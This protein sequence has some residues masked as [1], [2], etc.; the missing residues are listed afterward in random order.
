M[1]EYICELLFLDSLLIYDNTDFFS[2]DIEEISFPLAPQNVEEEHNLELQADLI[3]NIRKNLNKSNSDWKYKPV[4]GIDLIQ[5]R[6]RI[7]VPQTLCKSVLKW[8]HCYL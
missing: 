7:Y 3:T 8:Y 6:K 1:E 4:E 5:Y 2:L